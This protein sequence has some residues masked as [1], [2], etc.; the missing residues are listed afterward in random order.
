LEILTETDSA[1]FNPYGSIL[2]NPARRPNVKFGDAKIWHE[3]LTTKSGLDAILSYRK[4]QGAIFRAAR[5]SK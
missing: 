4:R 2:V 3:W 5:R 1:L